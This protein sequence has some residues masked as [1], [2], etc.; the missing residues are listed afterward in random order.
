M[1]NEERFIGLVLRDRASTEK[2][3][4]ANVPSAEDFPDHQ[5]DLVRAIREQWV[6]HGCLYTKEI[7]T[8]HAEVKSKKDRIRYM[9]LWMR[10]FANTVINR[11]NYPLLIEQLVKAADQRRLTA[12]LE[13]VKA[14]TTTVADLQAMLGAAVA[15][16]LTAQQPVSDAPLTF[17]LARLPS[18]V[19][20]GFAGLIGLNPL[21]PPST[22]I[23]ILFAVA[24]AAIGKRMSID[25]LANLYYPNIWAACL[26]PTNSNKTGSRNIALKSVP[27]DTKLPDSPTLE[28]LIDR[29][30]GSYKADDQLDRNLAEARMKARQNLAGKIIIADEVTGTLR[31]LV[32]EPMGYG[33]GESNLENVLKLA[34]SGE[35]IEQPRVGTGFRMASDL[36]VSFLGFSQTETWQQH[37]GDDRYRTNGLIGRIIP[38]AAGVEFTNLPAGNKDDWQT[39]V[40][41]AS[42]TGD[43]FDNQQRDRRT[44]WTITND[45]DP[46]KPV[47]VA[48]KSSRPW[49]VLQDVTGSYADSLHGK[50]VGHGLKLA[51]VCSWINRDNDP[52]QW[53]LTTCELVCTCY[54]NY[55]SKSA[56]AATTLNAKEYAALVF[57][58]ANPGCSPNQLRRKL[59]LR[60]MR[61]A[62][63]IVDTLDED[64]AIELRDGR[65]KDTKAIYPTPQ[66][67]LA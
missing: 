57:I 16:T 39:L 50:I 3:C 37:Y 13:K 42:D 60:D 47:M 58:R 2:W 32:G 12:T 64:R 31:R 35:T 11:D 23:M 29:L 30:G 20:L 46:V 28:A 18:R 43:P 61:E 45:N 48:L 33:R 66:F 19:A 55:F 63:L 65:R 7:A 1:S 44:E 54:A 9:D 51:M 4:A 38:C 10:C 40:K 5:R 41:I 21:L 6:S 52:Y 67:I 56:R 15:P 34:T 24:G 49:A 8:K 22:Q 14:G 17:D 26:S 27:E 62:W 25:N 36:C 59:N 53:L